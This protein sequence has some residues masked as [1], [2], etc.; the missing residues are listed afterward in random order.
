[1]IGW[2]GTNTKHFTIQSA[3]NIQ[4]G[5]IHS[6]EGEWQAIWAWRGPHRIQTF[7]WMAAHE[8]ILTNYRRSR[9]GI[10]IS[11]LCNICGAADETVIHVLR[12][13]IS[14]TQ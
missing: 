4:R 10:G 2:G 14:A 9:W 11:P 1:M 12:D 8:R 7:M 6:I 3:Y 13:C 5:H